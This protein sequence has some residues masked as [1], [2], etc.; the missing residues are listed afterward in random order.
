MPENDPDGKGLV[1][2]FGELF[3]EVNHKLDDIKDLLSTKADKKDVDVLTVA[4]ERLGT[5]VEKLEL[6]ALQASAISTHRL[7]N[8]QLLTALGGLAASGAIVAGLVIH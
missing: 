8:W 6:Q 2:S 1:F 3:A 5:R 4:Q 7:R